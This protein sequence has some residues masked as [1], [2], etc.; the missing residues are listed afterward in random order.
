MAANFRVAVAHSEP[1]SSQPLFALSHHRRW[2][3]SRSST[4]SR[5]STT[6]NLTHPIHHCPKIRHSACYSR[7]IHPSPRRYHDWHRLVCRIHLNERH[8]LHPGASA[9]VLSV[10]PDLIPCPVTLASTHHPPRFVHNPSPRS[11]LQFEFLH[12]PL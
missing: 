3:R 11:R 9:C 2:L 12:S 4:R 10:P 8:P 1:A 7:S 5:P 6:Q